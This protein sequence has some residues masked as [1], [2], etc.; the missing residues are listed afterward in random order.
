V[1]RRKFIL[2]SLIAT[3][4]ASLTACKPSAAARARPEELAAICDEKTLTEIGSAYLQQTTGEN[5]AGRLAG[6]I[7]QDS[8]GRPADQVLDREH[9]NVELTQHIANDFRNGNIV[10][11]KGWVLSHTEAR[12]CALLTLSS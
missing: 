8:S 6:L 11:V 7:M 12:L 5:D 9:I 3:A 1:K 2:L 4:G 10:V